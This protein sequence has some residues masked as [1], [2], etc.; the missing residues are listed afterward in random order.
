MS[1]ENLEKLLGRRARV[2]TEQRTFLDTVR[3]EARELTPE[4]HERITKMDKELDDLDVLIR[5]EERCGKAEEAV[6]T[7]IEEREAPGTVT[8]TATGRGSAEYRD[9]FR[10]WAANGRA[11]LTG[12]QLRALEVGTNSEGGYL[13]PEDFEA[14]LVKSLAEFN[15]MRGLATVVPTTGDKPIPTVASFGA[16]AW[17][18]E[19]GAFNESDDAFGVKTLVAHKATRLIKVSH[20]LL[21]DSAFPIAAHIGDSY[22]R[23]FGTLEESA[24]VNGDG[25]SKPTGVVQG[26]TLGVTAAGAAAITADELIDLVH[27]LRAP[28]RPRA[29]FLVADATAGAF[30]KLVDGGGNYL[31]QPSFQAGQPDRMMGYAVNISAGMPAMT[32]GNKSVLFGDFSH[33]WIGDRTD[34]RFQRLNELYSTT[35][36]VGFIMHHRTDGVLTLGEAVQHLIQA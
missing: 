36:Q 30:R 34:R 5:T 3:D 21:E 13:V 33:Y 28:Y 12:E 6:K 23:A 7:V 35:G 18:A 17:T 32:T 1:V 22:G 31:W 14:T 19:E 15:V 24:F 26:S 4:D 25:S 29:S 10:S 16:A 11:I 2:L 9:A 8:E 20:E 27:A